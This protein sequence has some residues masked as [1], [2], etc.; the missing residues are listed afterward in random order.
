M[1]DGT[2]D[3]K[4]KDLFLKF[5]KFAKIHSANKLYFYSILV[6]IASGC[7]ALLFHFLVSLAEDFT[8]YRLVG[9]NLG[10]P[11]EKDFSKVIYQPV[12]LFFLPVVGSFLST[13]CI[14]F[15]DKNSE[16]AGTDAMIDAFHNNQAQVSYKTPIVKMIATIFN[17]A[18]AGS[19]G[20]EGPISQIG[21]SLGSLISNFLGLGARARRTLFLAGMAGALG[22][23]FKAPLGAALV[24][25]EILYKKDFESDALIPSIIAS[26]TGYFI[27][28]SFEGFDNILSVPH[29]G[30][31]N[32]QEL[33][34]YLVLGFFCFVFGY[35][36]IKFFHFISK[37]TKKMKTPLYIRGLISGS[38]LGCIGLIS[39]ESIGSGLNFLY[40]T[41]NQDIMSESILFESIKKNIPNS[42]MV[43]PL[44]FLVVSIFKIFSTSINIGMGVSGGVFSPSLFIGGMLGAMV[45]FTAQALF[46]DLVISPVPY[47]I[48]GM[49]GF[50]AGVA[51][52]PIG[53]V[54]MVCELTGNYTLLT[55]L[56]LVSV[57]SIILSSK[58]SIYKNQKNTKFESPAHSW[59]MTNDLLENIPVK[60]IYIKYN[61]ENMDCIMNDTYTFKNLYKVHTK[62][63]ENDFI[64]KDKN[65]KYLGIISFKHL[66][67]SKV[68][69]RHL[70]KDII[71]NQIEGISPETPLTK[72]LEIVL[73]QDIDKVPVTDKEN[74]LLGYITFMDILNAYRE[75]IILYKEKNFNSLSVVKQK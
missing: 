66:L 54:I 60:D 33:Y 70:L 7:T 44:F 45:G 42:I 56:L 4:G 75:N 52:A 53:T 72:T 43:L 64:I 27:F 62:E 48:V 10:D 6:G 16:G 41:M 69:R 39:Y 28:T 13:L 22:A 37:S 65:N 73:Q 20:K 2:S 29:Y 8:F 3:K 74:T 26:L 11:S 23:I 71:T 46:P 12:F 5:R 68:H 14:H 58:W 47:I 32:W 59:E 50:F 35:I 18:G 57:L 34:I 63:G 67:L 30:F 1:T 36:F 49:G 9:L 19:A 31:T 15:F 38:I 17:L 40:S 51:N 25:V 55:P 61:K 21:A 24:A